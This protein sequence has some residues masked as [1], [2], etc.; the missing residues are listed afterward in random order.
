[1]A[2]DPNFVDVIDFAGEAVRLLGRTSKLG[3]V[4]GRRLTVP[5]L[6]LLLMCSFSFGSITRLAWAGSQYDTTRVPHGFVHG[7]DT[8]DRSFCSRVEAGC[9]SSTRR[10]AIYNYGNFV[11]D[12][13][14]GGSST[15]N[16]WP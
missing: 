16:A 2:S 10:C 3:N 13:T 14:V 8:N 7:S 9:G 6:V 5:L 15:C 12:L 1:M 4:G 11:G